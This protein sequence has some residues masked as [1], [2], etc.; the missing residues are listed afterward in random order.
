MSSHGC[1]RHFCR[2]QEKDDDFYRQFALVLCGL[3]S[4]EARRWINA[5]LCA[6]LRHE[7]D[8]SVD[9]AS[10]VPLVDGGTEGF[11]GQVKVCTYVVFVG[12]VSL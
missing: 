10:V 12:L 5:Q 11:R 7:E 3:D 9:E 8:G 1:H 2:I 6:L 4:L